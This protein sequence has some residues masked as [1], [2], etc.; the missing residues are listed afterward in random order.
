M[1]S[2]SPPLPLPLPLAPPRALSPTRLVHGAQPL[3]TFVEGARGRDAVER[4]IREVYRQHYGAAVRQ[5]APVLVA[6]HDDEGAVIAAA[7]YRAADL[8]PLFLER[9]LAAPV[10]RLL[11][12]EGAS[13][14][15]RAGIVEVGHLAS[16]RAG[17][18]RR[19]IFRLGEHLATEGFDW[20]VSTLTEELHQ[21]FVRLGIE[22]QRL[23]R[24][25]P[26]ALGPQAA[27]WGS[28]YDHRP[29]VLAGRLQPALG[30]LAR[31]RATA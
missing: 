13:V 24:A 11:A 10:E 27:D 8:A 31:R 9:Y 14:P 2:L 19:L 3:R 30:V 28:Y 4:F 22:P 6:L 17:A 23:G 5:F 21:L 16:G 7:G 29:L 12:E 1:L 18:G 26:H 15:C 25:E 20:V